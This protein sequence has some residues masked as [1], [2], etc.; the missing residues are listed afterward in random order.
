MV[1][2]DTIPLARLELLSNTAMLK[3]VL[4]RKSEH[5]DVRSEDKVGRAVQ[6][7]REKVTPSTVTLP[8]PASIAGERNQR[9]ESPS[10]QTIVDASRD[11]P[12]MVYERQGYAPIPYYHFN[13]PD[14]ETS[15]SHS[16]RSE[17]T[18]YPGHGFPGYIHGSHPDLYYMDH[19][20]TTP[21]ST[22]PLA[23]HRLPSVPRVTYP[24]M[25]EN[26]PPY[27]HHI[28]AAMYNEHH[29]AV[30][31]RRPG[32][33][34]TLYR[35]PSRVATFEDHD[36]SRNPTYET[37][38]RENHHLHDQLK[39]KD[40]VV[41]SLQQRVNYLE[42]QIGELRQLPTGKISHIPLE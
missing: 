9:V 20:S 8:S 21:A 3:K 32:M 37:L 35:S 38:A 15:R 18:G 28:G 22:T 41:S 39:E 5:M 10:P 16:S 24:P 13:R 31:S 4:D 29:H 23:S 34:E 19:R 33:T 7:P 36:D 30:D 25:K 11:A 2:Q 17:G 14:V 26:L 1:E 40:M 6:V 27:H 12:P 42:K